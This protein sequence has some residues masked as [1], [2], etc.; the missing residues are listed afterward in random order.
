MLLLRGYRTG[1]VII[2]HVHDDIRS[3]PDKVR[4][5]I[6]EYILKTDRSGELDTIGFEYD[7]LI[8]R[9]PPLIVICEQEIIKPGHLLLIREM[10]CEWN[11]MLLTILTIYLSIL[12]EDD[13]VIV[14]PVLRSILQER[15]C[16]LID[17]FS[18]RVSSKKWNGKGL[19]KIQEFLNKYPHLM[20]SLIVI[21]HVPVYGRN[22]SSLR[23]YDDV[24]ILTYGFKGIASQV[25][26]IP[27][28]CGKATLPGVMVMLNSRNS[29]D[30]IRL[31]ILP[32]CDLYKAVSKGG[33]DKN[34]I[35]GQDNPIAL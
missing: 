33:N 34:S 31:R 16:I 9:F 7:A 18:I 1:P 24:W 27:P 10:F 13:T 11:E 17:R 30:A 15:A 21:P 5:D 14:F 26:E 19:C 3:L 35:T 4:R 20:V 12:E 28:V 25:V 8:P 6:T 32:L 23:P 29:P 22:E 2:R